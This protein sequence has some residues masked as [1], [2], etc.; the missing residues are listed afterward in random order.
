MAV[1]ALDHLDIAGE[2]VAYFVED[3]FLPAGWTISSGLF[4]TP[5]CDNQLMC[6]R[7]PL[8]RRK[9]IVEEHFAD[10]DFMGVVRSGILFVLG[11]RGNLKPLLLDVIDKL[12]C[13]LDSVSDICLPYIVL[14]SICLLPFRCTSS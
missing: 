11:R 7:Y 12:F 13:R 14:C 8:S 9:Q 6:G 2:E 1:G 10:S 3:E 5:P 4:R